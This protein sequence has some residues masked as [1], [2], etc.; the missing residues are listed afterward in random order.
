MEKQKG[1]IYTTPENCVGCNSCIRGCPIATANV[2]ELQE[3]GTAKIHINYE[4]C[5]HCGHCIDMCKHDAREYRDDVEVFFDDLRKGKRMSLVVAPAVRTNFM[6]TYKRL[7]GYLKSM[8]VNK[9][10]DTSFGAEITTWAYLKKIT[11]NNLSG[12]I[13][14]PCPAIVNYVEK[15]QT[16]LLSKMAPIHS[17][18]MCAAVYMKEYDNITDDIAFISPCIAKHDEVN[19]V[20]TRGYAQYNVTYKRLQEY[21][22]K[23]GINLLNYDEAEFDDM[24]HGYG[25]IF[26]RPGGL[27]ENVEYHI[28][29][30]W[31]RQVEGQLEAYEYLEGYDERVKNRKSLPVLVDILNC[32]YGCNVGTGTIKD[33]SIDDIDE[34]MQQKK[35]EAKSQEVGTFKKKY[36]LF[37]EFNSKLD[38]E[39]FVRRYSNRTVNVKEPTKAEIETAYAE[40]RKITE[41]DKKIDCSACG[42][43]SCKEMA[44]AV[45]REL[46]G[47]VNC[48]YYNRSLLEEEKE[49]IQNKTNEVEKVLEKV[50]KLGEEREVATKELQSSVASITSALNEVSTGNEQ[51]T[52]EIDMISRKIDSIVKLSNALKDVVSV[53][54]EN[55]ENYIKSSEVIVEIS[56]QTNLLSLN[57]SIEAARAGEAGKGFAVVAEEVRKLAEETKTSAESTKKNNEQLVPYIEKISTMSG[58][59]ENEMNQISDAIQN[60]AAQSEEITANTQEIAAVANT[61]INK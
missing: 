32:S 58:N 52:T 38:V 41:D 43:T 33:K 53:I 25:A 40:L 27:K 50:R 61:I 28:G 37:E 19:S 14:Q 26:S 35:V 20:D 56:G 51:T 12:T 11:E 22:D 55:I 13:A 39:K 31:V 57:A 6:G 48:V 54:E 30:A 23:K 7:F 29:N 21:L 3:D 8:G 15:Y 1:L 45:T 9:I 4:D 36:K 46:N 59:L 18:M 10:Y 24:G 60:I 42:Y 44:K 34:I 16:A 47:G 5:I 17:P 49:Q 2:S